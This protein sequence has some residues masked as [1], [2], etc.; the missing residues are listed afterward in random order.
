MTLMVKQVE[1]FSN[2][3]RYRINPTKSNIIQY[4]SKSE[5]VKPILQDQIIDQTS[6]TIHLGVFRKQR[7]KPN[8]PEHIARGRRTVYSLMGAGCH[9][10]TGISQSLKAH[11]WSTYVVPRFVYGLETIPLT[12]KKMKLH[13]KPFRMLYL[14]RSNIYLRDHPQQL[15]KRY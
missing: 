1:D 4:N 13:L 3:N 15:L 12:K 10:K 14:D 8:I 11:L 6:E 9:G 2:D 7:G 5:F